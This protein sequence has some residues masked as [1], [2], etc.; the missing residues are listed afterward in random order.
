MIKMGLFCVESASFSRPSAQPQ[1][2]H[3]ERVDLRR[4]RCWVLSVPLLARTLPG[5]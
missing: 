4:Y 5:R 2:L 1:E 3:A